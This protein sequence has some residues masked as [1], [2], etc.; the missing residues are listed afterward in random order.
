[1]D[2]GLYTSAVGMLGEFNVENGITDNLANM[3]T[4]GYK[5]RTAVQENFS[6]LLLSS[7]GGQ[8]GEAGEAGVAGV[9]GASLAYPGTGIGPGGT[10]LGGGPAQAASAIGRFGQA[11]HIRD[12]GLNLAQG[13]PRY[14]G[15]PHDLMIVGDGFFQ[16]RAGKGI[17]LTRNGSLHRSAAGVLQTAEGYPLLGTNG[18]PI[19]APPGVMAVGQAGDVSVD[20]VRVGRL[21]LARVPTGQPLN[22]AGG[23]YYVG[24]GRPLTVTGARTTGVLQGY[25]ESSNVDMSTQMSSMLAAQRAY[26]ADS[27]MLQMQDETMGLAVN[28][29]GK[30]SG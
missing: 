7:Q 11:P 19:K 12:Y 17:L 9:A 15:S 16:A 14:T 4:P 30:V 10:M 24:P 26:Q 28:D 22:E 1:M 2:S 18:R 21:A 27:K 13:N 23:G 3:Q 25:L 5:E 8:A 20:G 29:L 6:D